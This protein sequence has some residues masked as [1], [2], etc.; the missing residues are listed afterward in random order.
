MDTGASNPVFEI[1]SREGGRNVE[2]EDRGV[3]SGIQSE[4]FALHSARIGSLTALEVD[5]VELRVTQKKG[6]WS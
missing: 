3:M 6:R 2:E 5:G 1:R 4:T